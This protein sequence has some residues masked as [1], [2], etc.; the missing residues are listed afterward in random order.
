MAAEP[1][2]HL[3][4]CG[5]QTFA[6]HQQCVGPQSEPCA[7]QQPVSQE[8]QQGRAIKLA[9]RRVERPHQAKAELVEPPAR[10]GGVVAG[11]RDQ[12]ALQ[13]RERYRSPISGEP[14]STINVSPGDVFAGQRDRAVVVVRDV[15][16]G[17]WMCSG[18]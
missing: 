13:L 12:R 7:Q 17:S 4:M 16:D 18:R 15:R 14:G 5:N 8:P 2:H 3:L 11:V 10:H 6:V 1:R 9:A